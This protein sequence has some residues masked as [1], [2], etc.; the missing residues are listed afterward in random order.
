VLDVWDED[1]PAHHPRFGLWPEDIAAL[2]ATYTHYW[3]HV[4]LAGRQWNDLA[5]S[6]PVTFDIAIPGDYTLLSQGPVL[7]DGRRHA[8]GATVSLSAGPH[9]LTPRSSE[10]D[11]R[12]LWGRDTEIPPEVPSDAPI[13]TGL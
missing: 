5:P 10:P 9:T 2:R 6:T 8:A 4:Y 11:L 3:G 13:Y 12:L 7:I 1:S